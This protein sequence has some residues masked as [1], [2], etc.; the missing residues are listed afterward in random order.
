MGVH[1]RLFKDTKTKTPP[2]ITPDGVNDAARL[3]DLA[4]HLA[5][6]DEA[7]HED[8]ERDNRVPEGVGSR[9]ECGDLGH[10]WYPSGL[11]PF[12]FFVDP[13]E[14]TGDLQQEEERRHRG[15]HDS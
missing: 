9:N 14:H 2:S 3:L 5:T 13:P 12:C 15:K 8:C 4:E 6:G 10:L 11:G 1:C 7:D